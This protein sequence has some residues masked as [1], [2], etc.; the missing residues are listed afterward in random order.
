MSAID[1]DRS[2][3]RLISRE[4]L[5][6]RWRVV[7]RKAKVENPYLHDLRGEFG[8][9]LA[10]SGVPIHQVRDALGHAAI[11]MTSTSLRTRTDLLDAA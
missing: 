4:Q 2:I 9:Q 3:G 10:E 5:C 1:D 8:S 7:C 11:P 6:E